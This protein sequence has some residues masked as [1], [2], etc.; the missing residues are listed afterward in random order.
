MDENIKNN[1]NHYKNIREKNHRS[2]FF[3]L[4]FF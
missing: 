3:S 1:G 4:I 2:W